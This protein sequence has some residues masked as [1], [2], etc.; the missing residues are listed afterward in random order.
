M[1]NFLALV[2]AAVVTF[3]GVGWYLGWYSISSL[4]SPNGRQSLQV[5]INRKKIVEDVG[6]GVDTLKEQVGG[7]NKPSPLT[8]PPGPA[9][10]FFGPEPKPQGDGGKPISG[11]K[12]PVKDDEGFFGYARP[13][14]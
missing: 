2:G 14:N 10:S 13:R 3:A 12:P 11:T 4:P 8:T 9:S 1:R 6:K 7:D 5:D